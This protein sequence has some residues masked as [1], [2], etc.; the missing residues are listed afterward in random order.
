MPREAEK[1]VKKMSTELGKRLGDKVRQ[2][3]EV[4]LNPRAQA[5]AAML[6]REILAIRATQIALALRVTAQRYVR[7]RDRVLPS[8]LLALG[9]TMGLVIGPDAIEPS[10]RVLVAALFWIAPT[11]SILVHHVVTVETADYANS[12]EGLFWNAANVKP[13]EVRAIYHANACRARVDSALGEHG[14]L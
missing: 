14:L 3:F 12:I 6:E 13:H 9:A 7:A 1:N 10:Y 5:R 8:V 11:S 4:A 2:Y